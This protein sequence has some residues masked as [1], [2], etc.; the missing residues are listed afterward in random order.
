MTSL[1]RRDQSVIWHPYTQHQI[2]SLT[3]PLSKG[4]GAFLFDVDGKRY[5][6]LISSWWV[7][8]HGH[9]NP[10]IAKAIYEQA[11]Q[12][13]HIIFAGF[14]HEPA[15]TLAEKIVSILP[16]GFSKVFYSDN[17]STAIE[18]AL[19]M[20][21]QYW[22]NQGQKNRSRFLAFSG[23]YHGDTFGAMSLGR[24]SKFFDH[25]TD[26]LFSVDIAPYPATWQEDGEVEAKEQNALQWI[27]HYFAQHAETVAAVIIEPLIQ[28]AS[29]MNICRPEFL[30]A[31]EQLAKKYNVL[32]IYDEVMTGF[33]RTGELFACLKAGTNPDIVCLAKGI[34]G[35]F[36]PLAVTVCREPIYHA[37]LSDNIDSAL[38]HGHSYTAN[39]LG[40]AAGVAS[41]QL[42]LDPAA[43]NNIRTIEAMHA[44][45]LKKLATQPKVEKIRQCGTMAA[46]NIAL[47]TA[48]GSKVSYQW[49]E[50]FLEHGLLL[51]PLGNVVYLLPP[52]CIS[53]EELCHAY[54]EI[55]K[56][57]STI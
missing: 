30:R 34:T 47:P 1:S 40:C 18:V 41:L 19:K 17:G 25:F 52:Y 9:G 33:G 2:S 55:I 26:L 10:V 27:E 28:G 15:I 54:E 42:L 48:Y 35:G 29:G 44:K 12:L 4:E 14:T 23:G 31:L 46:F 8:I 11:L 16:A 37:F 6:D 39:P 13:E 24:S 50:K 51:R 57:L 32:V 20:A 36:L 21:Y 45:M 22:Y 5:L 7:N 49:R 56:V 53:A 38:V 3:I 43:L